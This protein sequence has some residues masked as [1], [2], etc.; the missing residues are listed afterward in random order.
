MTTMWRLSVARGS[1]LFR[2]SIHPFSVFHPQ[3]SPM[4]VSFGRK[5]GEFNYDNAVFEEEPTIAFIHLGKND[6]HSKFRILTDGRTT[7]LKED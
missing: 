1:M 6:L 3:R 7:Y 5:F 4:T 2:A